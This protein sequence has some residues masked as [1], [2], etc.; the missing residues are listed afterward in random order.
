MARTPPRRRLEAVA[1]IDPRITEQLP[2]RADAKKTW[3]G[4]PY[5]RTPGRWSGT[6]D[7]RAAK[8]NPGTHDTPYLWGVA[9]DRLK[10]QIIDEA[11]R[12]TV[13]ENQTELEGWTIREFVERQNWPHAYPTERRRKPQQFR[14]LEQQS[15]RFISVY[16]ARMIKGGI[17]RTEARRLAEGLTDNELSAIRALFNSA[18][19]DDDT[20]INPFAQ[21]GR[22][23]TKGRKEID[24]L[25]DDE[26]ELLQNVCLRTYPG[27]YGQIVRAAAIVEGSAAIRPSEI[28]AMEERNADFD[29]NEYYIEQ[30]VTK[31][32]EL[33]PP[34]N[35]HAR[36]VVLP[37]SAVDALRSVP[38][39]NDRFFIVNREGNLMRQSTWSGIWSPV[40]AA[41][42]AELP[43][44]HWIHARMARAAEKK[45]EARDREIARARQEGREPNMRRV[46]AMPDGG[47][48][49]YELR[50]RAATYMVEPRP[51]GL[52]LS[53]EDVAIQL[54]HEDGGKLVRE[55]YSH[56]NRRA[57]LDR[58]KQAWQQNN[59]VDLDD[60][61][62]AAGE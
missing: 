7:F 17:R 29:A 45:A 52:G 1:K 56:R 48:D 39:L 12:E 44:S 55:T 5:Q 58:V 37:P 57:A 33:G 36:R 15:R 62:Q 34:K 27:L 21:L 3:D 11:E 19:E 20:V 14:H 8:R 60:A 10:L 30:Q 16:G 54:G 49:F 18:R 43:E 40:R 9:R 26:Y 38:R 4:A 51:L 42:H 31:T 28:W 50:H 24:V 47:F 61:R 2:N 23:K 41:F 59:V 22:S 13:T 6:F 32:G 46:N 25:T 35:G 53:D